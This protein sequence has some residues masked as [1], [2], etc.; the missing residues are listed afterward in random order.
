M[1]A[2]S[3]AATRR[4][5]SARIIGSLLPSSSRTRQGRRSAAS[6]SVNGSAKGSRDVVASMIGSSSSASA[7]SAARPVAAR[8]ASATRRLARAA[9]TEP[10]QT[11]GCASARQSARSLAG[12]SVTSASGEQSRATSSIVSATRVGHDGR[13]EVHPV[14]RGQGDDGGGQRVAGGGRQQDR[15]GAAGVLGHDGG[16]RAGDQQQRAAAYGLVD[17][18][19]DRRAGRRRWPSR[20]RGRAH[21]PSRAGR[22]RGQATKGTGQTGSRIARM[23][24]ASLPAAMT[25]RGRG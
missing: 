1:S 9:S 21:R 5:W 19:D 7:A 17:G 16:G 23:K 6:P 22:A 12:F 14:Q 3:A 13:A 2:R 24:R 15:R 20:R 10:P 25:A 4:P 11:S 8:S 18:G